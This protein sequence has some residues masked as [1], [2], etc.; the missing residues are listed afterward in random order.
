MSMSVGREAKSRHFVSTKALLLLGGALLG[1]TSQIVAENIENAVTLSP[2]WGGQMSVFVGEHHLDGDSK[3][4]GRI[5][6]NITPN[7]GAE[8]LYAECKTVHDPGNIP[9]TIHQYGGD[10]LYFFRPE[11]RIVPFLAAGFGSFNVNSDLLPDRHTG[12][13]NFGAGAE[14]ALTKWLGLRANIRH[15][16][17]FDDG[18]NIFEGT[19]GFRIQLGGHSH[20]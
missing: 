1:S 3:W 15:T 2:F 11:K 14:V 13:F 6:Y 20:H 8:F 10:V 18:N 9:S 4:G 16:V 17:A 19:M 7:W 12:Y 5:G